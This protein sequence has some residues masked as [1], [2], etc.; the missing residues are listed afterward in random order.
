MHA[1]TSKLPKISIVTPS[2]NQGNFLTKSIH[3]IL[4]QNYP[5]LEY[6]IID[7][8]STDFSVRIIKKFGKKITH[9]IS[10]PDRGQAHAINKGF[11]LATGDYWGW[12][13]ADDELNT[14][15]LQYL[16]KAIKEN[17]SAGKNVLLYYGIVQLVDKDSKHI[18]FEGFNEKLS[19]KNHLYAKAPVLQPG[20][21][22]K[23]EAVSKVGYLDERLHYCM[24]WDLWLKILKIGEAQF[25]P[26]I[27]ANLRLHLQSKT[28]SKNIAALQES[29][30][31]FRSH[32]GSFL[33]KK[34]LKYMFFFT[35]Y[36]L[37]GRVGRKK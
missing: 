23:R 28:S 16:T 24:D 36:S 18:K 9:W 21:F 11:Q 20:S 34:F 7:G 4:N 22:Y 2:L 35:R 26:Y 12:L 27:M 1:S 5:N 33:S 13:N 30:R 32:G 10:E 31:V 17:R 19:F 8:G 15:S 3:S 14:D 6:I 25:I 29:L 37:T